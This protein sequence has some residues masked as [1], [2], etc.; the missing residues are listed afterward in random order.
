MPA[1]QELGEAHWAVQRATNNP[2]M[3]PTGHFTGRCERCGSSDLETVESDMLAYG[4]NTCKA[5]YDGK[6]LAPQM[7][8]NGTGRNFGP[9]W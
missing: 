9:A 3:Q 8:E 1:D 5:F 4:C 2:Q 6:G 7:I